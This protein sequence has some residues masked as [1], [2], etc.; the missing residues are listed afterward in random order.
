MN[1]EAEAEAILRR[2]G[3]LADPAI[4]VGEAALAFAAFERPRVGLARY[5]DHLETLAAEVRAVAGDDTL[6]GRVRALNAVLVDQNGYRGDTLTYDDLQNANLMRVI[7]RRKG[8]PVALGILYIATAQR[9]GWPLAGV[10]FPGHFLVRLDHGGGS[11]L[12]DPFNG[13]KPCEAT[14]LRQLLKTTVGDE[15][16]LSPAYY[17]T[18]GHRAV[19]L[20]LQNN[21]KL[22]LLQ[23]DGHGAALAII[24]RMRWLAPDLADLMR[25]AGIL[26][27]R[28]GN[29]R[30]AIAALDAY[31]GR[32][33]DERARHEAAALLQGLK[34]RLN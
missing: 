1:T 21:I 25:E 3:D 16:E 15:A 23:R 10:N 9:L 14:T 32:A 33:V 7:D 4:D 30:A 27:A 24:E 31:V 13:G 2:A 12:L 8:L 5:R 26:H 29:V 17:R 34:R 28:I 22:R 20:R 18:V 6:D 19:L 11:A